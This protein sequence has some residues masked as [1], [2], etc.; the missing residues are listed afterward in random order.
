[1]KR[2]LFITLTL[3]LFAIGAVI[4]TNVAQNDI[5]L[6]DIKVMAKA[7]GLEKDGLAISDS[8]YGSARICNGIAIYYCKSGGSGCNVSA[9]PICESTD[10]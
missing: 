1:M 10:L 4:T 8:H 7:G 2:K 6:E 3:S 9:Q 5:S